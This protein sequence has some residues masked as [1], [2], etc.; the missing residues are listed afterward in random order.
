MKKFQLYIALLLLSISITVGAQS[1]ITGKVLEEKSKEPVPYAAVSIE[2]QNLW[3]ITNQDGVFSIP[4]VKEGKITLNISCLG[5]VKYSVVYEDATKIPQNKILYL[6]EDNLQLEEVTVTAQ[7]KQNELATSYVVDKNA[8]NH[9]QGQS[10]N[11]VMAQMPGGSTATTQTLASSSDQRIGLRNNGSTDALDNS[12]FGTAIEVDGIR[13]SNNGNFTSYASDGIEGV[14]INNISMSNIESIEIVT[15]LP[16]VEKGDLTS[17]MVCI[18]TKKGKTPYEIEIINKP[19]IKSF[20][21]QKGFI[22]GDNAGTLNASLEHTSSFKERA[23]P[24]TTYK[25]NNFNLVYNNTFHINSK[26]LVLT[27]TLA[28]NIGGFNSE[29]DPDLTNDEYE[30]IEDNLIRTGFKI[31]YLLDLQWITGLMVK[32]SVNYRNKTN[33]EKELISSSFAT[34]AIHSLENGY[35]IATDYDEDPNANITLIPAGYWYQTKIDDNKPITYSTMARACLNNKI[36]KVRS[37]FKLGGSFN[38]SGNYGQGV[39]YA[40]E[41]LAPTYRKFRYD[42]Q[43]FVKEFAIYAE[44]KVVFPIF[45]KDFEFQIGVRDD[46]TSIKN[47]EYGTVSAFSPRA[48]IKY[49]VFDQDE[50]FVKSINVHAGLGD[51]VKLPS[52]RILF[53]RPEYADD[54]AFAPGTLDDGTVYYAYY[55]QTLEAQYNPDLKYQRNRKAEIGT[56]I[57]LNFAKISLTGYWEKTYNPYKLTDVYT[58]YS[59]NFTSQDA[60]ND[61]KISPENCIY[62]IDKNTGIVTVSDK[63]GIEAEQTLDYTTEN[64]FKA[65]DFYTNGSS[66]IIK[67]GLEWIVDF[68]T[69]KPLCTSIRLDGAYSYYKGY[70]E[71]LIQNKAS[72]TTMANGQPYKYLSYYIGS[73]NSSNGSINKKLTSNITLTTHIPKL[74]LIVSLR[75]ESCL[76]NSYQRI[77]EYS[78]G[79]RS[80]VI[81]DQDDY[82]AST[83]NTDIYAGDQYV[84]M[85]P[86]YYSTWEDPNTK[87]PFKEAFLQAKENDPELYNELTKM[88]VKTNKQYLFNERRYTPYFSTNLNITKEIGDKLSLSF[89]ANNFC[90]NLMQVKDSQTGNKVSLYNNGFVPKLY[91]G[92]SLRLKL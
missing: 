87:I 29:S 5:F 55:T 64:T 42:D 92:L 34:T 66:K 86:L 10:I 45:K 63:T 41:S 82:T 13:L 84:A 76:L 2:E 31:N 90:N 81:D 40:D 67:Q 68:G 70:D 43:P 25:R 85:Y 65:N 61:C 52:S 54:L 3:T 51:A 14:G 12:T 20:S 74:R 79:D 33:E 32:G 22:L 50:G 48:N 28:G 23:S 71:T 59:F 9:L 37:K 11:A 53:P 75:F 38:I 62:S 35:F 16:S 15:G 73:R 36:G 27:Y 46:I 21:L 91:Y 44:E 1:T 58:P 60:L 26:P 89:L 47:S 80:F 19:L 83:S 6:K 72:S 56:D 88:V 8:M 49:D 78:G 77:S 57:K 24:Y 30:K 18:K 17:G 4:N 7:K 69:I 39:H